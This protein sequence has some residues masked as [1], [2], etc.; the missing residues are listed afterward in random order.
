MSVSGTLAYSF[1]EFSGFICKLVYRRRLSCPE[2]RPVSL[3]F[4][5]FFRTLK[6]SF[7]EFDSNGS[8]V[9][10]LSSLLR[11]NVGMEVP[12][13]TGSHNVERCNENGV[14]WMRA[15]PL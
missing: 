9:S 6:G 7:G 5:L 4:V 8:I 1:Y 12:L 13:M 2:S 11:C 15:G 10:I 14:G 3:N